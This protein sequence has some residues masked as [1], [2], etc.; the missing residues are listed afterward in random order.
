VAARSAGLH[1]VSDSAPGI[2][3]VR[4]GKGFRYVASQGRSVHDPAVLR[5]ILSLAIPPAWSGV[6]I[7]PSPRGHIQAV[8]RDARRRKQY[9]YHSRWREVRDATKFG[10]LIA[11]GEGLPAL[12]RRVVRDLRRPAL[13]REKV[14]ATVLRLL[15]TTL[16]RVGNEEYARANQ[17]FGLTTLRDRHV[18][19]AGQTLEFQFRG[20]SGKQHVVLLSDRRLA[21]IVRACQDVPGDVLFQY[22]DDR[23]RAQTIDSADVNAYLREIAGM[24]CTAKLFRTWAGTMHALSALR[25]L[26]PVRSVTAIQRNLI[27]VVKDVAMKLGNTPAICRRCY[28]HPAVIECYLGGALDRSLEALPRGRAKRPTG[29]SASEQLTLAFLRNARRSDGF[30]PGGRGRRHQPGGHG[31]LAAQPVPHGN[32]RGDRGGLLARPR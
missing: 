2:R 19:I 12:R 28:I 32:A 23:G 1:C 9:R 4:A 6:W 20:K 17:S 14:L 10:E 26:A 27:Q 5:R 21:K 31:T 13:P 7:C 8:G 22:L 15:E 25:R 18:D 24:D 29:L 3:R 16:I 30:P 11:F